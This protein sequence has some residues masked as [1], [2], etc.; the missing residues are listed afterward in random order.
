M[1]GSRAHPLP[2]SQDYEDPKK[3]MRRMLLAN[4]A[5]SS[6]N[7]LLKGKRGK[8]ATVFTPQAAAKGAAAASMGDGGGAAT[9]GAAKQVRVEGGAPRAVR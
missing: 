9:A 7:A 6:L 8:G 4:K 1:R 2:L 5:A 3:A